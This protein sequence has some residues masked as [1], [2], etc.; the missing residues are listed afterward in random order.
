MSVIVIAEF[1]GDAEKLKGIFESRRA[2][3][4]AIRDEAVSRGAKHHRFGV[5]DNGRLVFID[6]WDSRESFEGFFHAQT[7]IPELMQDV[8]ATGPPD[9]SIYEAISSPDEF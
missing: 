1:S 4:E 8:G 6:E 5:G 2:D 3:F 9:F 7:K